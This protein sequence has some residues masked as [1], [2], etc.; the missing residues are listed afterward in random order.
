MSHTGSKP[1][2]LEYQS[3]LCTTDL[4]AGLDVVQCRRLV[5]AQQEAPLPE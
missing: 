5:G 1:G 2:G 3:A 4:S